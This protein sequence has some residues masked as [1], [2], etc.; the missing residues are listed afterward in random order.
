MELDRV[1]P[2]VLIELSAKG[3][4][5]AG[6]R[7]PH[8]FTGEPGDYLVVPMNEGIS[9]PVDDVSISPMRLIAYGGHG[10]CMGFFGVT[11]GTSGQM[12]ILET[13]DD[14]SIRIER[15]DG[16]LVI[17][18][19]WDSQQGQFG[20]SRRLRYVF[21]N[22]GGH[23]AL[24]KRY[25]AHAQDIGLFKTLQEKRKSN[26]HVDQLIGAVN[27]WCWDHDAAGLA[28]EMLTAGIE[29]I[30]WSN[31]QSPSNLKL[32]NELGVLTSRYDI[33]QDV[34]APTNFS[35]LRW[36][37]PDWTTNA[38]PQDIILDRRG[39]WIKGWGVESRDGALIPCGVLCDK[40][41]PEFARERVPAELSTHPYLCRFIDTTTAAPW[42]E[43][44]S[45]IH[46]MTRT[47]SRKWKM[48]LLRYIS[49]QNK[50]VT[51]SETGHDAAV[52][53]VHYFEGM[54]SLGPYRVPDAGRRMSEIWTNVPEP[55][56]KFQLGHQY[57][58]PLWELVYHDCVVA[59]WYWGDYNNK[60]P[61]LWD[62]RDL[63]NVL[64]GVPP[65]F[66]FDRNLWETTK[67]RFVSSY[68]N[69][70]P[71]VRRVGYQEMTDHRFLT[72]DRNVQQTRFANGVVITVNFG[73]ADYALSDK[74]II[75]S[76]SYLADG[77]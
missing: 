52:P 28:K 27:V 17:V 8:P 50:L 11:D 42:N 31:Q 57:R 3:E 14:A 24:A 73:Q 51:G 21:F 4:M 32:L 77:E 16:R 67:A 56:A 49:E 29:R 38:W 2:E 66:M 54:L 13:P 43:C 65:M 20:Y 33:Y 34:M 45:P 39:G 71:H 15:L 7:F 48:E 55:V 37:H 40:F 36:I 72:P 12:A 61:V 1:K 60:L 47:E 74:R 63:F 75:K 68:Q 18:P 35:R 30:L 58:L 70:C 53:F 64:Y 10:I 19:E 69:T 23:V 44:F 9:Y 22:R 62:K 5:P 41:G 25:R 59:Q 6:I 76:M 46:P 26:P